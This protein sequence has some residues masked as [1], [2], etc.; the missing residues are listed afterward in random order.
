M[1][2]GWWELPEED[3]PPANIWGLNDDIDNWFG[4]VKAR[5]EEKYGGSSEG[6][7]TARDVDMTSNEYVK[8]V[9]QQRDTSRR[10]R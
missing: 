6:G 4:M 7:E 5:R 8:Q 9:V 2:L 1:I 10:E 3:Q